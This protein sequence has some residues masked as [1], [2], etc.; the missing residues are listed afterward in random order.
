[1]LFNAWV[2]WAEE[3]SVPQQGQKRRGVFEQRGA[4]ARLRAH[5]REE[6]RICG[7]SEQ[8]CVKRLCDR[9][10]SSTQASA[11]TGKLNGACAPFL[12]GG[13][14]RP[15]LRQPGGEI[16][17]RHRT[18][19]KITLQQIHTALAQIGGLIGSL[20]PFGHQADIQPLRQ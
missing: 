15:V 3:Q 11:L 2:R 20:N 4:L 7:P 1:M 14:L 18:C 17:N 6:V 10:I 12:L 5:L 13:Q 8:G 19:I 16:F 9:A